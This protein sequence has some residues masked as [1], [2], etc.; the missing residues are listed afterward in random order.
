MK[1]RNLFSMNEMDLIKFNKFGIVLFF[2]NSSTLLVKLMHG[3]NLKNTFFPLPD[4]VLPVW[5]GRS[6]TYFLN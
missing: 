5:V 3:A 6:E 1:N 4:P 2:V